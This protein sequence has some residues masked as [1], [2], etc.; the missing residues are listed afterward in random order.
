[1]A[2]KFTKLV[3][4]S[5]LYDLDFT[6]Q[7]EIAAGET[8]TGTPTVTATPSGLTVGV[9]VLGGANKKVQVQISGGTANTAY[10]VLCTVGTN[11]GNTLQ[12]CGTLYVATC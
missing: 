2:E 7:K 12:G 9:P 6:D 1:M 11:G 4:E 10:L 3:G 8:L 5:R